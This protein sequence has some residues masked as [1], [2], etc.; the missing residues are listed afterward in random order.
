MRKG[1]QK[2]F[3]VIGVLILVVVVGL[4]YKEKNTNKQN[5]NQKTIV[6][7]NVKI[8]TKNNKGK[9][10]IK[11]SEDKLEFEA[12]PKY[13]KGDVIVSGITDAAPNGFIRKVIEIKKNNS[14]YEV[15]TEPAVLTDVFEKAD[16]Y[17]RIMLTENGIESESYVRE[18]SSINLKDT[19]I[20]TK[21]C[22]A[23][24]GVDI[25]VR[26]SR[27]SGVARATCPD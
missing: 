27:Q 21:L 15:K 4:V 20:Q 6:K 18:N 26:Q 11:V 2:I 3:I 24:E 25:T 22:K 19:K 23:K 8:I 10:P 12:D 5:T 17:Q 14:S 1:I 9:Q 7:K 13:K 16:I